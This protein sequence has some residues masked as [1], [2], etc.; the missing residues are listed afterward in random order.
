MNQISEI[1][2]TDILASPK[3]IEFE[4]LS[5]KIIGLAIEV[6]KQIGPGFIESI[7]QNALIYE[8][9]KNHMPFETEKKIDIYYK[10]KLVGVHRLDLLVNQEIVVELKA[11]KEILS[12]HVSQVVSY[13]KA[14]NL[15]TGLILN[16]S[17]SKL[18]IKRVK[19]DKPQFIK[20]H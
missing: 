9:T 1:N 6:H 12:G 3:K 16:F 5:N 8:L 11:I 19:F 7:Y 15:K 14:T 20:Y 2:Y 17:K 10:N 4:S 13:L 18:D